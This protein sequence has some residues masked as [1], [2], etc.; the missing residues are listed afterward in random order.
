MR[1]TSSGNYQAID[2]DT[3]V[4]EIAQQFA[5]VRGKFGG[6]KTFYYGGGG[7]GNQLP[8]GYCRTFTRP[9]GIRYRSTPLGKKRTVNSGSSNAC[10]EVD[11]T[12]TLSTR[13]S[14]SSAA[15]PYDYLRLWCALRSSDGSRSVRCPTGGRSPAF[16]FG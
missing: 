9:L 15:M 14:Q 10:S 2:W 16:V 12:Q 1:R 5:G 3:V 4:T 6:D 8:E 7:Q 11:L 13:R